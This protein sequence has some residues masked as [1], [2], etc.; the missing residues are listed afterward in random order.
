[1]SS[2]RRPMVGFDG[3]PGA[4]A[5]L[6]AGSLLAAG[7]H[8]LLTVV[9][10][11]PAEPWSAGSCPLAPVL[12][13]PCDVEQAAVDQLRAAVQELCE[14][15]S[16]VSLLCHGRVGPTLVREAARHLCDAIVIGARRGLVSRLTGGVERYLRHH[17]ETELVVVGA[18]KLQVALPGRPQATGGVTVRAP[19]ARAA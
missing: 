13:P 6:R 2:P 19:A 11:L 15:I 10:V 14:D 17:C 1:M 8:G 16:V 7:N 9:L 4:F 12:P 3:S 18:S 5:A